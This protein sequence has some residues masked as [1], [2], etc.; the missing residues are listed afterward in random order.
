MKWAMAQAEWQ[1]AVVAS[2]EQGFELAL[3]KL[4]LG[5]DD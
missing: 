4:I 1:V 5:R 2:G 3:L